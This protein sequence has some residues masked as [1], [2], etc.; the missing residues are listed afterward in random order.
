MCPT[1][2]LNHNNFLFSDSFIDFYIRFSLIPS[3]LSSFVHF[4]LPPL[5]LYMLFCSFQCFL[6]LTSLQFP[7]SYSIMGNHLDL[8]YGKLRIVRYYSLV[9]HCLPACMLFFSSP[10]MLPLL[11]QETYGLFFVYYL[12]FNNFWFCNY[13]VFRNTFYVVRTI[14]TCKIFYNFFL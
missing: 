1:K 4:A 3:F 8:K 11:L 10:S 14:H 6:L 9:K 12:Y 5:F 13:P 2:C 7:L